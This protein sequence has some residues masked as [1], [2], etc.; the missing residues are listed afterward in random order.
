MHFTGA[1]A[2]NVAGEFTLPCAAS[3]VEVC[4]SNSAA[5]DCTI[6]CGPST[7]TDGIIDGGACGDS[8]TPA[9]FEPADFNGAL[10]DQEAPYH[11]A[12]DTVFDFS[13]DYD[14]ASGTAAEDVTLIFWFTEG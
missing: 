5:T 6:D 1:L 11:M 3:L 10:C 2:A 14:G 12:N 9:V 4:L 7:D 8:G 13:L